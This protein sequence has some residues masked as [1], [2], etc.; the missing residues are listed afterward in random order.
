MGSLLGLPVAWLLGQAIG[1][2]FLFTPLPFAYSWLAVGIW[3]VATLL[4]GAIGATRPARTAARLT[5]REILA[6]E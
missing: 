4:I 3:L 5:I 2:A 6:Y 1:V